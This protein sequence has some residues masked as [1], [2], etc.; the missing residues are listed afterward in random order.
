MVTMVHGDQWFQ[1][2]LLINTSSFSFPVYRRSR[3][4]FFNG[5]KWRRDAFEVHLRRQHRGDLPPFPPLERVSV[6]VL[7]VFFL[8]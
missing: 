7:F 2:F 4:F 5:E 3:F 6:G 1:M 8:I